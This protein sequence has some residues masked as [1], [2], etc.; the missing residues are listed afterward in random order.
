VVPGVESGVEIHGRYV[1][2]YTLRSR[3]SPCNPGYRIMMPSSYLLPRGLVRQI[4]SQE[5]PDLVECRDKYTLNDLAGLLRIG[6]LGIPNYRPAVIGLTCERMDENMAS[7]VSS[8]P[9]ARWFCRWYMRRIY[10]PMFDHHRFGAHR[11][12]IGPCLDRPPRPARRLGTSHGRRLPVVHTGAPFTG[13]SQ[14]D[15]TSMGS[16]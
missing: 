12:R 8:R 6:R 11:P 1:R 2:I 3:P 10:F 7:Y 14:A 4:L 13:V 15:G 5:R 9:L 16:A